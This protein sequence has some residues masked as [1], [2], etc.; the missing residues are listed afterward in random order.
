[1]GV[2]ATRAY[3][4]QVVNCCACDE[5]RANTVL[6]RFPKFGAPVAGVFPS[7]PPSADAKQKVPPTESRCV[8]C[9]SQPGSNVVMISS[10]TCRRRTAPFCYGA[11]QTGEQTV[12]KAKSSADSCLSEMEP[13]GVFEEFTKSCTNT[14]ELSVFYESVRE[15]SKCEASHAADLQTSSSGYQLFQGLKCQK[16]AA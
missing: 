11:V 5:E 12:T 14:V 7:E 1:M 9:M 4:P 10:I 16:K 8:H 15:A 13:Y 6:T 2:G 3:G